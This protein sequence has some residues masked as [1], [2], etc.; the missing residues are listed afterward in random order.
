MINLMRT[1]FVVE[2]GWPKF[3]LSTGDCKY[4]VR[5]FWYAMRKGAL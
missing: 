1:R 2:W 3:Y 5:A 4:S